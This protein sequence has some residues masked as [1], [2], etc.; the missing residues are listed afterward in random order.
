MIGLPRLQLPPLFPAH[1]PMPASASPPSP[2]LHRESAASDWQFALQQAFRRPQDLLDFLGLE[3]SQLAFAAQAEREF[4]MR[5]PRGF[6]RRMRRGD[7]DDPLLRQV[8][9]DLAETVEHPGFHADP[10]GDLQRLHHGGIIHKYQGRAL[11][12]TT[13]ACAV[14]CRYCFRR[15]FP[16]AEAAAGR[17]HWQRAIDHIAADPGIHEVLLSGGDPLSLSNDR[18]IGLLDALESLPQLRRIRV[19]TRQLV[20][21]PERIDEALLHRIAAARA[22]MIFVIHVNHPNEIDDSVAQACRS[23]QQR[24]VQ[25]LNQ[26]VLL[27][28]INDSADILVALSEKLMACGVLPYY[29]HLLDRVRGAAH[30]EVSENEAKDLMRRISSQ[31]SGYLVPRLARETAGA[32]AKQVLSW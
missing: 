21:L 14:H 10:V 9:P 18:L 24:G 19:H 3:A 17:D 5:V 15:H 8:W 32:P 1:A 2:E 29:L 6:A 25:M 12:V 30:F 20:V 28:N 4:P 23:L 31:I 22:Q 16:Y 26:S 13:G 27:R 11:M 7:P